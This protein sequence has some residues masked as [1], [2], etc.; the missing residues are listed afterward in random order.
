ME[1]KVLP[2]WVTW[3]YEERGGRMTKVPKHPV[4]GGNAQSNNPSTWTTY[5]VALGQAAKYDG[6]GLMFDNGV[7]GID[8]DNK[9][10]DPALEAQ[11]Q[12]IIELMD[13]YTE[14]SP[15]GTGY[16]LIFTCDLS[17]IPQANGK[18]AP[19]YYQKNPSNGVECYFS[20]L[21]HRFFTYTDKP[22]NARGMEDRTEQILVFLDRYMRKP[23]ANAKSDLLSVMRKARNGGKFVALY[24]HGD[25]TAYHGDDSAADQALCN[26]LAFYTQGDTQEID[27]LFRQS[28][29]MRDK[30][31]RP[32]YRTNTISKAI[33]LCNGNFYG[34]TT[35]VSVSTQSYLLTIETLSPP[36]A[37]HRT[38]IQCHTP[39]GRNH[40]ARPALQPRTR[41]RPT[42]HHTLR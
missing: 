38:P 5:G 12:A 28:A 18:L 39:S 31:E 41:R 30:W 40:R 34:K 22:M 11:A 19:D 17:R 21:T 10:G 3:K 2:Q 7:C 29:L 37:R 6:I 35:P 1:L 9:S 32:D 4:S 20:G 42:A 36:R 26:I 25:T 15:S 8:L 13:T 27:R 14:P 16:H 33:A 24:D 23:K